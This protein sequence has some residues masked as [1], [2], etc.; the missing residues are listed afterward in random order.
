MPASRFMNAASPG[1]ISAFQPNHHYPTH[2]AY[3]EAVADAMQEEYEAIAKAGIVLQLDCP[4]LAMARHT[5]SRISTR[6]SSSPAEPQVEALNHAVR[7]VPAGAADASVLGQLRGAARSRYRAREDPA[8][9][10]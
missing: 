10:S 6:R 5:G 3:V 8:H 2:A 7:N 4:D 1:V 9:S